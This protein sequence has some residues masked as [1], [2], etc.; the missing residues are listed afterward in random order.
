M[1]KPT[2]DRDQLRTLLAL[3][4]AFGPDQVSVAG[5]VNEPP[6]SA[7]PPRNPVRRDP[8]RR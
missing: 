2:V 5:V 1:A 8:K 6:G 3:R 4:R 7:G